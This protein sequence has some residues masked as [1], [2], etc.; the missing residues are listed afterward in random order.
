MD[1]AVKSQS[2]KKNEF[3]CDRRCVSILRRVRYA[4]DSNLGDADGNKALLSRG[5]PCMYV[6]RE[7]YGV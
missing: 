6:I 2:V 5:D 7:F 3:M 4:L 1:H